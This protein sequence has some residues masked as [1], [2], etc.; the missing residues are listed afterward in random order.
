MAG[1]CGKSPSGPSATTPDHLL[2]G[3]TVDAIDGAAAKG[4]SVQVGRSRTVTTDATGYFQA[5]ISAPGTYATAIRGDAVVERQTSVSAPSGQPVRLSLIPTSFDLHAWDEMMRTSN[6]RLQRWTTQ[7]ALVVVETVMSY[8]GGSGNVYTA[9]GEQMSADEAALM[10]S[11]LQ[12]G[13]SLLTGGTYKTFASVDVER[14]ASG[15]R[16]TVARP[17]KIVVGRY[18]GIVNLASTIGYGTWAENA[19]GSVTAG[20]MFLD[21]DFDRDDE[22]R[23]LLRIHELGHALGYLHV[24]T[25]P[26]IMNPSIG[27]EPT[28]FD[29]AAAL[30]AF[31]RPPGNHSP[32]IDPTVSGFRTNSAAQ[33]SRWV[34]PI[35]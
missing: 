6:N 2:R 27:P 15:E 10:V 24:T 28:S 32:D 34:N 16:V 13:L 31:Q 26:S 11:H 25:R 30:I 18:N 4:L 7:P 5:D 22:R 33:T 21:R 12:E 23:R 19:D 29:R 3:Q 14:P 35:P 17:G 9:S 8:R 1:G 20:M